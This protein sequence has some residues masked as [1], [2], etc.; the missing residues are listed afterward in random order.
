MIQPLG[1][2]ALANDRCRFV[3]WAPHAQRVE[4]VL[5]W[6]RKAVV[7]LQRRG[8]GYYGAVVGNVCAGTRYVYRLDEAE[9]F[10][11][12]ASRSQP[13]GVHGASEVVDPRFDW[14]DAGWAGLPLRDWVLYELHVGTFTSEGTF[15]GVVRRLRGLRELGITAIELMPVA[16]FPGERNWGYDGVYPH[17]VQNSYGGPKGLNRLVNA[18][19]RAGLAVVLDVV[20]NHLGPEGNHLE[21][22][23]PYFTHKHHTPWGRG[24]NFD[25][26]GGREVRRF[27]IENAL[28]WQTQ[29]HVDGLR[30]DAIEAIRDA[31]RPHFLA[32]LAAACRRRASALGRPFHLIGESGVDI[33][34]RVALDVP[35]ARALA[36]Q[37]RDDFHH[38]LHVLLTG[39]QAGY[40]RQFRGV[41]Q[42]AR[43]W[44]AGAMRRLFVVCGQNH[45]R[46]GNRPRGERLSVLVSFEAQKLAAAT[47]LLSPCIPLIFM[48]EE[49]GEV[50]PF[51]YFVSHSDAAV[52]RAVREGRRAELAAFGWGSEP[53]DPQ[54][55]A[56]FRRSKLRGAAS[57][58]GRHLVLREFY[59]ELMRLRRALPLPSSAVRGAMR[60]RVHRKE[61]VLMVEYVGKRRRFV[62][63]FNYSG[64]GAEVVAALAAGRW[65]KRLDSA[66]AKWRGPG[67]LVAEEVCSRGNARLKL[68]GWSGVVLEGGRGLGEEERGRGVRSAG[69]P[70]AND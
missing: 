53:A 46:V 9:E 3:V 15:A 70:A 10:P 4:L 17:A 60:V 61:R 40:Y 66:S 59:R 62:L 24:L 39:E 31:S 1:A 28:Y 23:G 32:E 18:A 67:G 64:S 55:I 19:H 29:F 26:A 44:R 11:D 16:Q 54:S 12:P 49:Y 41:A 51:R 37:W 58:R 8:G 45:D 52:I 6:P 57:Q 5:R 68:P 50:A 43:V 38:C 30:L 65:S 33:V 2:T 13:D 25:Q 34:R 63:L 27:F 42:F 20:Y 36:G 69:A 21:A 48:G 14:E 7:R 47:V 35:G 22:F 56:S